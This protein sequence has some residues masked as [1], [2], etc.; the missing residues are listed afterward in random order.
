[1]R[2]DGARVGVEDV[3]L[4]LSRGER[5]AL[6]GPSGGGKS[7]LLRLLAGLYDPRAGH[8]VVD[9]SAVPGVKHLGSIATLIPQES[10]VFEA[11]VRENLTFGVDF[12]AGEIERALQLSAFDAVVDA[13]PHGLDTRISERGFNLSG[14]QRQRLA[15][16]R[17]LLAARA[18][19]LLLLDEPTSALD[20]MT[21]S[22]VLGRLRGMR[23]TTIVASVHRMGALPHFDRLVLMAEG[24]VVDTGT[25][26]EVVERQPM[27]REMVEAGRA[28]AALRAAAVAG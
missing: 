19:S 17:G 20:Q 5:I 14:G 24:R 1:V 13:L 12:P 26:D 27:L 22:A 7:T 3:Q 28:A 25:L 16:A 4:T 6:I 9:G 2:N 18:S 15:L 21:E 23:D 8:Y 10:D 11:T